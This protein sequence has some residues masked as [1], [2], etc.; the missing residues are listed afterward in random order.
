MTI[1]PTATRAAIIFTKPRGSLQ[2]A[3]L[4]VGEMSEV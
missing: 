3:S 2:S 4:R 1:Y